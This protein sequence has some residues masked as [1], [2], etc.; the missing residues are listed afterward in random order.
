M[1][2][3]TT[4]LESAN[5]EKCPTPYQSASKRLAQQAVKWEFQE[6]Q[7]LGRVWDGVPTYLFL[8]FPPYL[9][10][11]LLKRGQKLV[12]GFVLAFADVLRDAGLD[13]VGQQHL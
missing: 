1:R 5:R 13:V 12:D 2:A 10:H 6:P 3:P 4:L 9:T 11:Q 7:V 8:F